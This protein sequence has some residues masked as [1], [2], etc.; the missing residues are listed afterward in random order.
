MPLQKVYTWSNLDSQN[1]I[2]KKSIFV[3]PQPDESF[4]KRYSD[5]YTEK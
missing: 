4:E 2:L 3:H 1:L 5:T